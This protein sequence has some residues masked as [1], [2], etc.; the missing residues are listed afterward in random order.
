M[1]FI[2][3]TKPR[4]EVDHHGKQSDGL[5]ASGLKET[6]PGAKTLVVVMRTRA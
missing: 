5:G 3:N 6:S 2:V 4:Q 1:K